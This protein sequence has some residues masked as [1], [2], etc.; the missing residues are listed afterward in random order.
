MINIK[1]REYPSEESP[2]EIKLYVPENDK[3]SNTPQISIVVPALNEQ[4]TI[5]E[6][7]EWCWA[8]INK[9]EIEG[10]IIIVDSSTDRTPHIA[11]NHGARVLRTPKRGLGQAYIDSMPYIKSNFIIMGDCDLTYDFREIKEFINSYR[12]G[13]EFVMGSRFAGKIEKGAMPLLHRYFGT[14]LT[15]WILN[16]IYKSK[17]T[18]IHCGMRG[19]TKDG[20]KKIKLTSSGWEYASEM[21]LKA[22]RTGLRVSEVPVIFY[23]DRDGRQSHL[24]RGGIMTPWIAGWINLKVMLVY[25]PD[26]FLI[27]PGATLF[28]SGIIVAL[29]ALLIGTKVIG[30]ITIGIY[31]MMLALTLTVLGYAMFQAGVFARLR[32]G[33]R[34]GVE[35]KVMKIITYDKGMVFAILFFII[36]FTLDMH[37]ISYWIEGNFNIINTSKSAIFGLL[38]IIVGIQTFIFTLL[39]ELERRII[40]QGQ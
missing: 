34:L 4:I 6:F 8:G 11:L 5:G 16:K 36:G 3:S 25:S 40:I 18:D 39:L 37:F 10:E 14:P 9:A 12:N 17:F 19:I 35:S 38:L 1:N 15:T 33:L 20:L 26:S 22:V 2:N 29:L 7:I 28:I 32:H 30:L 23:K 31:T 27:K 13:N 24:K 21:V